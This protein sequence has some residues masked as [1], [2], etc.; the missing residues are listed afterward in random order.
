MTD[1]KSWTV[2]ETRLH[3]VTIPLFIIIEFRFN[4]DVPRFALGIRVVHQNGFED[5]IRR[6]TSEFQDVIISGMLVPRPV[7]P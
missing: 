1:G 5:M 7:L 6:G 2:G 3:R 4:P